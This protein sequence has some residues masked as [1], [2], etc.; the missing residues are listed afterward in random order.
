MTDPVGVLETFNVAEVVSLRA[1]LLVATFCT[2]G[3]LVIPE[4]IRTVRV[5]VQEYRNDKS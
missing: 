5:L 2:L 1:V 4:V 3:K